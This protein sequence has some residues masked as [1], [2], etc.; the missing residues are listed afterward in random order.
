MHFEQYLKQYRKKILAQDS[1]FS[2]TLDYSRNDIKKLIP[3]REPFLLIDKIK[4]IDLEKEMILGVRKISGN[5]PVFKGHFPDFPVYP[6]S[7]QL[8]MVGQLG[9]CLHYFVDKGSINIQENVKPSTVRATRIIG[10]Y[11]LLPVLP[12]K[13]VIL[14]AKK[15]E[16]DTFFGT[17]IG[18]VI[19]EGKVC[20][21]SIS[22]VCFME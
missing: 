16:Y 6:G 13:E 2:E 22:E 5:D 10:A 18:Q 8:E 21:V 17:I 19:S 9:L 7:L 3:H 14:V 15:L 4:G 1:D 11:F 12:E 20:S